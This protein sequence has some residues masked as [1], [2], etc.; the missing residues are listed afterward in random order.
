MSTPE[1]GKRYLETIYLQTA[2]KVEVTNF[3]GPYGPYFTELMERQKGAKYFVGM[4]RN[5]IQGHCKDGFEQVLNSAFPGGLISVDEATEKMNETPDAPESYDSSKLGKLEGLEAVR[6]KGYS[7]DR[8]NYIS[9]VTVLAVPVFN[10][11]KEITHTPS[12]RVFEYIEFQSGTS[13]LDVS[14]IDVLFA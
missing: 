11:R 5:F 1:M 6:K 9:G 7:I 3:S 2:V 10:A 12:G 4:P 13:F 14:E 8:G